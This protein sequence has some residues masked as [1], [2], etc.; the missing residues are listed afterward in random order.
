MELHDSD[1]PDRHDA[2]QAVDAWIE[3]VKEWDQAYARFLSAR[4]AAAKSEASH[5]ASAMRLKADKEAAMAEL[6]ELKRKMDLL[7]ADVRRSRRPI[8]DSIVMGRIEAEAEHLSKAAEDPV[9]AEQG[10]A[11]RRKRT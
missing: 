9:S 7:V 6:E 5:D 10:T 11:A 1:D 2:Q 8:T 3:L 4:D